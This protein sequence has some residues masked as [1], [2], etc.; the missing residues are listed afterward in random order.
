MNRRE[1]FQALPALA[2]ATQLRGQEAGRGH[3][4]PGLVAYSFRKA[5]EAK[6]LTYDALIRYVADLGLDGLDTTVYW[7]PDTSDQFLATLR[8]AAYKH[9]VNLYSIATRSRLCQPTPEL[10]NAE[11]ANIQKW[12]DVAQKIGATHVRVFG[13]PSPKGTTETQAIAWAVETV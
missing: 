7:F 2:A 4:R 3:L 8:R 6:K 11:V 9:G 1:L 5:L 10:Q 13:G 12:V